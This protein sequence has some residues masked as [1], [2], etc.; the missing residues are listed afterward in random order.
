[1]KTALFQA[2][3]ALALLALGLVG[4]GVWYARVAGESAEAAS[5]A[6]QIS[7]KTETA[8][9]ASAVRTALAELSASESVVQGYSLSESTIVPFLTALES[10]GSAVGAKVDV[11]SV[12]TGKGNV[13][14]VS[15]KIAGSFDAVMRTI[16]SVEYAPYDISF[17][18]VTLAEGGDTD[19]PT[20]SASVLMQVGS[21]ASTSAAS[22]PAAS[23]A[24]AT[25]L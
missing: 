3:L 19:T 6:A 9:R 20:W 8:E 18:S 5:L 10:L 16:G 7:D 4:Y 24:P 17:K 11:L 25:D 12:G 15:L 14:A 13:L 2:A 21:T 22:H 1:M 23:A